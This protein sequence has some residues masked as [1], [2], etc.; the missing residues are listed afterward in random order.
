MPGRRLGG[1]PMQMPPGGRMPNPGDGAAQIPPGPRDPG[2]GSGS[3]EPYF[4]NIKL[5]MGGGMQYPSFN[6]VQPGPGYD[7]PR[8]NDTR[9]P[10]E[11]MDAYNRQNAPQPQTPV[12]D[13]NLMWNLQQ[14]HGPTPRTMMMG[15][16]EVMA[17]QGQG[18]GGPTPKMQPAN[19]A[20]NYASLRRGSR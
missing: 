2:D 10:G 13:P 1:P 16:P 3:M 7:G 19:Y 11:L 6:P 15:A 4:G 8:E 14:A 20:Q 12:T 9:S 5:G 17:A 18:P